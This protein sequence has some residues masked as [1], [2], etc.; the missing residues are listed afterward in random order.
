MLACHQA[1]T[2]SMLAASQQHCCL[3]PGLHPVSPTHTA[4][5]PPWLRQQCPQASTEWTK[6]DMWEQSDV[7]LGF[8]SKAADAVCCTPLQH[9]TAPAQKAE[10]LCT[11]LFDVALARYTTATKLNQ[12][13][14]AKLGSRGVCGVSGGASGWH[15]FTTA[16]SLCWWLQPMPATAASYGTRC[17]V[18]VLESPAATPRSVAAFHHICESDTLQTLLQLV[19][20][21]VGQA[22]STTLCPH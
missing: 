17:P 1:S 15:R 3:C 11:A 13:A 6:L 7:V 10:Q 8:A 21:P 22:H 2:C 9:G 20:Q 4:A 19:H 12:Q 18:K 14:S 5:A 16:Y